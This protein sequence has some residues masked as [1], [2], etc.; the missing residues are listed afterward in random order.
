MYKAAIFDLDGTLLDTIEDLANACNYA[1]TKLELPQHEVESYKTFVGNGIATLMS[2]MLPDDK[3]DDE[4]IKKATGFFNEHYDAHMNDFTQPF[5]GVIEMLE[6]LKGEGIKLAVVSNKP[7]KYVKEIVA[8]YFPDMFSEAV[9]EKDG[10]CKP[11]P[12]GINAIIENF[13]LEKYEVLF[14]GDSDVDM[15]TASN[16]GITGC[17]AEWGFRSKGEL[18]GAGAKE[19]AQTPIMV[20]PIVCPSKTTKGMRIFSLSVVIIMAVC[21]VGVVFS[22]FTGNVA[23]VASG[24]IVPVIL[25]F[26]ATRMLKRR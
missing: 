4:T 11:N 6:A 19:I 15:I 22:M 18:L 8:E 25:G 3:R 9:G 2:R 10:I 17:G 20:T 5:A 23:G 26:A 1:L 24:I 14:I 16:A 12:A 13:G 21:L 7:D